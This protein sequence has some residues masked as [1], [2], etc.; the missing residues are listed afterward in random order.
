MP[1][2][3][4][5]RWKKF[6]RWVARGAFFF[7][8]LLALLTG[9]AAWR[10]ARGPI[11]LAGI[12][13]RAEEALDRVAAPNTVT[14]KDV[15]LTWSG[16]RKPLDVKALGVALRNPSG[17]TIARFEELGVDFYLP[18]LLRGRVV[19]ET[20]E[21]QGL[22]LA[23]T[24][25]LDGRL[26]VGFAGATGSPS[27]GHGGAWVKDWIDGTAE[28]PL[29]R[30]D[31]IRLTGASVTVDDKVFG[32]SW[33]GSGIELELDR[34]RR[35][36]NAD[37]GVTIRIGDVE[38][39]TSLSGRFVRATGDVQ[40]RLEFSGLAPSLVADVAPSMRVL[41][42][43]KDPVKGTVEGV[44]HRGGNIEISS[45]VLDS[46]YG[47]VEGSLN[48][49]TPSKSFAGVVNL[50]DVR[51]WVVAED[52]A[53][54]APLSSL[55]VPIDGRV[56]F[57]IAGL[58]PQSV[59]FNLT[60][61][62]GSFEIPAPASRTQRIVGAVVEGRVQGL[63]ALE[64]RSAAIDLG[65]GVIVTL[66]G[67]A[68]LSGGTI[69]A[70]ATAGIDTITLERIATLW[71]AGIADGVHAWIAGHLP[72]GEVHD[73]KVDLGLAPS[74]G[75]TALRRLDGSFS[76]AG[77]RLD[78]FPEA[79]PIQQ[80]TG[81]ANFNARQFDFNV[82][83]A[84][85]LDLAVTEA[86]ATI[87]H[88]DDPPTRLEVDAAVEGPVASA[89][90]LINSKPLDLVDPSI[91]AA[92]DVAG[93][94]TTKLQVALPIDG[95]GS[96]ELSALDVRST[97]TA[98]S[99]SHAPFG[100]EVTAGGLALHADAS[101][102]EV[103]GESELNGVTADVTFSERFGDATVLRTVEATANLDPAAIAALGLPQ[104]PF[105]D[106]ASGIDVSVTM[107][108]DGRVQIDGTADLESASID[109]S[110]IGWR[111][112][113][114]QPASLTADATMTPGSGW[115]IDTV[116]L[117]SADLSAEGRIELGRG[118]PGF[119]RL[120]LRSFTFGRCDLSAILTRRHDGYE[121]KVE[122]ASFDLTPLVSFLENAG[123]SRDTSDSPKPPLEVSVRLDRLYGARGAEFTTVVADAS[124]DGRAWERVSLRGSTIPEGRIFL[125]AAPDATGYAVQLH[126]ENVGK[127]AD[128]LAL[129][130]H[131]EGGTL[132][133]TAR[134]DSEEGP[135]TGQLEL[136]DTRLV[137]STMATRLL[138]LASFPGLLSSFTSS[139][140]NIIRATTDLSYQH[141]K[142]TISDVRV[143]ADGAGI[144]ANGD[145]DFA[146]AEV[147]VQGTL[148]PVHTLQK[149]IGHL[150]VLGRVLT[151][152]HREG[153]VVAQFSITGKLAQ[154]EIR[155]QPL[156]VLTPGI[157]RDLLRL[158]KRDTE[159]TADGTPNHD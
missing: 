86:S 132:D 128:A 66:A 29:G 91:I 147:D 88:L 60:A 52:L 53:L 134:G 114:G 90:G 20:I 13:P 155:A 129:D 17:N 95:P 131:F 28:G 32:L 36:V 49:Q 154:P 111:K 1:E 105:Y 92:T 15:V 34:D 71:P 102:L 156:S 118:S 104:V 107:H 22:R 27:G 70:D 10:L 121:I 4:K 125:T 110:Q 112:P 87:S 145:I 89:L 83:E 108:R 65:G 120:S 47:R 152:I 21:L 51:P 45:F 97:L 5:A 158:M 123:G 56:D 116:R 40:G 48:A 11:S 59:G 148:A 136:R 7:V 46:L 153:V 37:L 140:L 138:R 126:V 62:S 73:I 23:V 139:G 26:D 119:D 9:L 72:T 78:L 64:L 101:G 3:Q 122:G 146:A 113:S 85:L 94:A 61:G 130:S 67:D 150:P 42:D 117:Q 84:R 98:F 55:H 58:R 109:I 75:K 12:T 14:V 31:H 135:I 39:P 124:F 81:S 93:S 63:D 142:L 69:T 74:A 44:A 57:E 35:S 16:W 68:R 143:N 25:K 100:L 144:V 54:A 19:P 149:I 159:D 99:W 79:P 133:L 151:G 77:L 50:H 18:A 106:G 8:I 115:T 76:Y 38:V 6:L 2:A 43:L 141:E 127:V 41:S 82:S 137:E 33:G 30:L 157:T 24:R 103:K 96:G 80:I